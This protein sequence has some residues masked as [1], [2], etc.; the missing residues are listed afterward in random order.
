MIRNKLGICV[1]NVKVAYGW[2]KDIKFQI[3]QA[4]DIFSCQFNGILGSDFLN[5]RGIIDCTE[6]KLWLASPNDTV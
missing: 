3:I 2:Y 6:G 1:S 4:T 5:R